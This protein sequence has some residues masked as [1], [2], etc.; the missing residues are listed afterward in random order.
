MSELHSN[1]LSSS[2]LFTIDDQAGLSPSSAGVRLA[3]CAI[4]QCNL[5]SCYI[6]Y[7]ALG[8]AVK[9]TLLSELS[10]CI[11][12]RSIYETLA[13]LGQPFW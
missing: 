11:Y 6:A 10:D 9:I 2:A 5:Y 4:S 7:V 12:G 8:Y 1:S 13:L 3:R